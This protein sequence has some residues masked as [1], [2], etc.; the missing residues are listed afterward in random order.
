MT[1][2]ART[3]ITAEAGSFVRAWA[4]AAQTAESQ[5]KRIAGAAIGMKSALGA[6]GVG[7]S[8][9]GLTSLAHAQVLVID[10]FNDLQD[11]TGSSI[12]NI[13][14]LESLGRRTGTTFE[15]VGSIL[16]KFNAALKDA[17]PDNDAGQAFKALGLDLQRLRQ[18]DPAEALRQT[19][20]ALQGFAV[21]GTK[22]RY[23]QELFGKSVREAAPFLKDL[24]ESG[25]LMAT[26]TAKQAEETERFNKQ[27]ME[28]KANATDAGREIL[29][30]LV[31]AMSQLLQNYKDI[32]ELDSLDL[33]IKDAARGLLPGLSPKLEGDAGENINKLLAERAALE[34]DL[35]RAE[36]DKHKPHI[37][38]IKE[39]IDGVNR[40]L[41]VLR[42]KQ[43]NEVMGSV[44]GRDVGDAVSRRMQQDLPRLKPLVSGKPKKEEIGEGS[45]RLA[46]YVDQLAKAAEKTADLSE[47]QK[48]LNF[49]LSLGKSG[50]VPQV[51]ELVLGMAIRQDAIK[52][53]EELAK[54]REK[55]AAMATAQVTARSAENDQLAERLMQME[56]EIEEIGLTAEALERLKLSRIDNNLAREQENLLAAKNI[57]G[58]ELEIAQI[59]RRINLLQRERD[60][61]GK[62]AGAR[63]DAAAAEESKE[64]AATLNQDVKGALSNAFRDT[65]NPLRA[66]GDA[67]AD[68]VYT[69][70]SNAAATAIADALVGKAA[71]GAIG[72]LL[73]S[74]FGGGAKLAQGGVMSSS[75]PLPLKMYAGGGVAKTPQMAIFGEGRQNEAFVPL[76]DG[77]SIPV[78]LQQGRGGGG[79][80]ITINISNVIGNIA[81]QTDVVNGM[82][83]VRATLLSEL[84][85]SANYRGAMA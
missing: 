6:L 33:V 45:T 10:G 82:K 36:D 28:L 7:I 26:V 37:K 50:E 68:V 52:S 31:P 32:K 62:G 69:R 40:Y 59:E 24:A 17:K 34:R 19:A 14:G 64:F 58:N 30:S 77:R 12:E 84:R 22:A 78:T 81:S 53:E 43:R 21:D 56:R 61:A 80:N 2:V 4:T 48:A 39:E 83:A 20:I 79:P 16:V 66:F 11:A 1:V 8:V 75:G 60:L 63:K 70:L 38:H 76:P 57:E 41:A 35:K 44:A 67:L 71:S 46:A 23:V 73:G 51:R 9:A 85:R 18:M 65:K 25:G 54:V 29:L 72:G 74:I 15:S 55:T 47:E 49:L 5:G 3:I 13:S 42:V 27:L